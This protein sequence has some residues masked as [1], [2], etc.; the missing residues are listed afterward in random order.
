[1]DVRPTIYLKDIDTVRHDPDEFTESEFDAD[2]DQSYVL[3]VL[4]LIFYDV[5][6]SPNQVLDLEVLRTRFDVKRFGEYGYPLTLSVTES[7]LNVENPFKSQFLSDISRHGSDAYYAA[8]IRRSRDAK[9]RLGEVMAGAK[10][11]KVGTKKDNVDLDAVTLSEDE[12]TSNLKSNSELSEIMGIL[13]WVEKLDRKRSWINLLPF[14]RQDYRKAFKDY[15]T[16]TGKNVDELPD[17]PKSRSQ[18]YKWIENIDPER[19]I[20]IKDTADTVSNALYAKGLNLEAFAFEQNKEE[21]V[22]PEIQDRIRIDFRN[23]IEDDPWII[24]AILNSKPESISI[25]RHE[26]ERLI[27]QGWNLLANDEVEALERFR[28]GARVF[29]RFLIDED[30][31]FNFLGITTDVTQMIDGSKLGMK[32]DMP[33]GLFKLTKL[34]RIDKLIILNTN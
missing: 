11:R 32:F 30:L 33:A 9:E 17:S 25:A 8:S 20:K 28:E 23:V 18:V 21:I 31:S 7:F 2:V 19:A 26:A 1:M 5:A 14:V 27:L 4:Y 13:N 34:K 12:I 16:E 10:S 15:I 22:S 29:F 3:I 24:D 6:L